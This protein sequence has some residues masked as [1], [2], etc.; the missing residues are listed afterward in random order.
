MPTT[1]T[2]TALAAVVPPPSPTTAAPGA[3]ATPEPTPLAT[4][5]AGKSSGASK[6][7]LAPFNAKA[8]KTNIANAAARLKSC[9]DAS[10]PA[11]SAS[12]VITFAPSGRVS[13][14]TVTTPT[15][16]GTRAGS[17]IV[18]KLKTALVP[19]FSGGPETVKKSVAIR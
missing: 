19:P 7:G 6:G 2:L 13:D 14:V 11:G 12:V 8:A 9:K 3:T 10:T 18:S 17:C 5:D 4:A 1:P 15:Y 16:A